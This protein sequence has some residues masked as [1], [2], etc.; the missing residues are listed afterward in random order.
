[1]C[2]KIPETKKMEI[3]I[4]HEILPPEIIEK[5]LKI[6]NYKDLCQ[7]KQI[8]RRWKEIIDKGNLVKKSQGKMLDLISFLY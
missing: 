1:M 7:A 2:Y 5:T 6:L 8:C 3:S 4:I